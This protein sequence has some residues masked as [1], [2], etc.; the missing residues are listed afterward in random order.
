[1]KHEIIDLG[2]SVD[3]NLVRL[4]K[5]FGLTFGAVDLVLTPSDDLV[6]LEVNPNGQ[7]AWLEVLTGAPISHA[8]AEYFV[9]RS[10]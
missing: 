10:L 9:S 6:F 1:M 4:I 5:S 3:D 2:K 8:F 7:W